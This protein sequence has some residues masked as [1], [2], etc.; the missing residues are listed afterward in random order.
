MR[1]LLVIYLL[2]LANALF[3]VQASV[4][5]CVYYSEPGQPYLELHYR[6]FGNSLKGLKSGMSLN[7]NLRIMMTVEKAGNIVTYDFYSLQTVLEDISSD[8]IDIKRYSLDTGNY[9]LNIEITDLLDTVSVF[10]FSDSVFIEETGDKPAIG[11]ILLIGDI[12]SF[13]P[14]KAAQDSRVKYGFLVHPIPYQFPYR[15]VPRTAF[16]TEIYNVNSETDSSY[17]ILKYE[18]VQATSQHHHTPDKII[19]SQ[20]RRR[21]V[22]PM[23]IVVN[24]IDLQ[25]IPSGNYYIRVFAQ[26]LSGKI[27]EQKIHFFQRSN[28]DYDIELL[29]LAPKEVDEAPDLGRFQALPKDSLVYTLKAITPLIGL[30]DAEVTKILIAESDKQAMGL[31]LYNHFRKDYPG[32]PFFAFQQFI[33]VADYAD[34]MF[35]SGF[36]HGFET[37]RGRIF[38]KYGRPSDMI[39]VEDEINAPPYEIWVYNEVPVSNQTNVKFLFYNPDLVHNGHILLHSTARGEFNNP[40]WQT[41]LYRNAPGGI[42]KQSDFFEGQRAEDGINRR[43]VRYFNDL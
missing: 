3:A 32:N 41:I 21:R 17:Y 24:P 13:S 12:E 33:K 34:K 22:K 10:H 6:I 29:S 19:A 40:Q 20:E 16:Y 11:S 5:P 23:D 39:A 7:S 30:Y 36:R 2:T 28:P 27:I 8:V 14:E 35:N 43:A 9:F 37:D 31:Y 15:S 25:K 18:I 42:T 1:Y 26:D 38:M 4:V